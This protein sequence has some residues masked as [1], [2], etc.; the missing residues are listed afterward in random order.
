[1]V[2]RDPTVE[3]I[4]CELCGSEQS[5]V[6]FQAKER[7]FGLGGRFNLVRCKKCSLVYINPRPL[8]DGLRRYYPG[9]YYAYQQAPRKSRTLEKVKG[10]IK[11]LVV[12]GYKATAGHSTS[13]PRRLWRRAL[14]V[15]LQGRI[16]GLPD[17]LS[18][19]KVL[20][21]G[22]GT[23]GY[24][25]LLRELGWEVYGVEVDAR[26]CAEAKRWGLGIFH[27]QLEEAGFPE[28]YFDL[29]RMNH[30]L[31]HLPHPLRSLKEAKRVLRE[32]GKLLIE[33]PNVESLSAHLFGER[34]YHLDLPRHLF[35]FSPRTLRS[36]LEKAGFAQV[37]IN[38][39]PTTSGFSGSLQII[40][41]EATHNPKGKRLRWSRGL[42]LPLWPISFLM[43][44]L[45][46][47]EFLRAV[48]FKRSRV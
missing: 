2:M 4:K 30:V 48:A 5:E 28:E 43:A 36:L 10:R 37:E 6:V 32:G 3:S 23:G 16:Q 31:E 14:A 27:G 26:A 19:G 34:W 11:A 15:P 38:H 18:G 47:G 12:E 46:R 33:V 22:C 44:K 35:H 45:G 40:W 13:L 8:K 9:D 42:N 39:L 41:N 21:V 24:L 17:Y 1:M 29:V 25:H 7:R 20:D